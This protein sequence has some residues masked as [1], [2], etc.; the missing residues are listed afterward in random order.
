MRGGLKLI[1]PIGVAALLMMACGS[2]STGSAELF[3]PVDEGP[4]IVRADDTFTV[5]SFVR[6]GWKNNKQLDESLLDG[7]TSAWYGFFNQLD[8][9]LWMY[10][11]NE[12]AASTG[13]L[14]AK[15]AV[16]R[17]SG[18]IKEFANVGTHS[19]GY[20]DFMLVG[21]VLMMCEREV[22]TCEALVAQ[23]D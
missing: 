21:N 15:A 1:V 18:I 7:T 17:Q 6:A 10:E 3:E 22:S 9:E 4:L 11:T 20:A 13:V 19:F 5:D 8:I 12:V 2:D 16:D 23:L 14:T